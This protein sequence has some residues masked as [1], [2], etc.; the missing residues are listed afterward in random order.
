MSPD[1][2]DV[3]IAAIPS[4][5]PTVM[6]GFGILVNKSDTTRISGEL[7]ILR[8]EARSDMTSMRNE[9]RS[10]MTS[11]RNELRSDM[12]AMRNELHGDI[13]RVDTRLNEAV[14]TLVNIG[15]ELDKRVSRLEDKN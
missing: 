4:I 8:A 13:V 7:V 6:V 3:L 2:H 11:I 15:N 9:L 14:V 1:L 5:I 12:N 10:D